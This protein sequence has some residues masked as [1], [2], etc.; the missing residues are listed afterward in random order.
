[1]TVALD[2]ETGIASVVI[3]VTDEYGI[4]N[5]TVP[6]FGSTV[7]LEAWRKGTDKDGRVYTISAVAKDKAGN[8]ST[9]DTKVIVPHDLRK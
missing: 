5:L 2:N 7:Y 4:Y 3:T 9:A 8:V 6:G 1:L